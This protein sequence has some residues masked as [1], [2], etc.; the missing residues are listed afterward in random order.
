M[1]TTE[2]L[3][4]FPGSDV[5]LRHRHIQERGRVIAF[6][7]Q[8]ELWRRGAWQPIARYDT[9]HG[10]AHRDLLHADGRVEKTPLGLADWSQALGLALDDL[11]ANWPW[12]RERFLKEAKRDD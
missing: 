3:F 10:F 5:Q 7:V 9:A 6:T 11:K 12:Y 4:L 8:L 2:Y 1:Q